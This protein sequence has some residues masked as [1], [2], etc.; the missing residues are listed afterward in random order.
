M[1]HDLVLQKHMVTM[2]L[3]TRLVPGKVFRTPWHSKRMALPNS[4]LLPPAVATSRLRRL[5]C[6]TDVSV[7]LRPRILAKAMFVLITKVLNREAGPTAAACKIGCAGCSVSA[8]RIEL[9]GPL[10]WEL[11]NSALPIPRA[12]HADALTCTQYCLHTC[13]LRQAPFH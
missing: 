10:C 13:T 12:F 1:S 5:V 9:F 4:L 11:H 3:K 6:Q 7:L 8:C 2:Q